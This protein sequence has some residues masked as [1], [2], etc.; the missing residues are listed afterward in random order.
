MNKITLIQLAFLTSNLANA[1]NADY[2]KN[3]ANWGWDCNKEA[4]SPIDLHSNFPKIH[5]HKD[6]FTQTYPNINNQKV[7]WRDTTTEVRI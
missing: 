3:G 1:A 4:Q 5:Y 6:K 2:S 7:E